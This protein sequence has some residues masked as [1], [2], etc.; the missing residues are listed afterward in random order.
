MQRCKI[1][2]CGGLVYVRS[3]QLCSRHYNRLI[4]T[5][6]VDDGPRARRPL[7]DRFWKNVDIRGEGD[8][9]P[10]IG[11][12]TVGGYGTI[13]TGGRG[14]SKSP[15]NRV[16]WFLTNGDIPDGMVV[17][18]TCHNRSCCNPSHLILGTRADNVQD[19]W[20]REDGAPKGNSR[21]MM[22]DVEEIRRRDK[23]RKQLAKKFGV[24]V[25]HIQAIQ[26]G[27]AWKNTTS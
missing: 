24:S 21:L 9:W 19:M 3:A 23:S 8:C 18:H 26:L 6:T 16:A 25:Y 11:A 7:S 14:A 22:S 2:G 12:S 10:W 1:E 17:R 15:S 13:S 5:G 4:T 27:R 20:D